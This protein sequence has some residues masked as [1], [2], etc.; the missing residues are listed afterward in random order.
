MYR[1]NCLETVELAT[2]AAQCREELRQYQGQQPVEG[3][4]CLELLR[5]ATLHHVDEAWK[6]L[7]ELFTKPI[8]AW[9]RAHSHFYLAITYDSEENYIAQTF[10]RFW[11]VMRE[12]HLQFT[13]LSA[14]LSYLRLILHSTII[15]TLRSYLR[16]P[17]VSLLDPTVSESKHATFIESDTPDNSWSSIQLLLANEK[18]RQLMYLLYYCGLK[19]REVAVRFPSLFHDVKEIYRLN[20]TIVERLRRNRERLRWMLGYEENTTALCPAA[21]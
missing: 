14:L 21:G 19:P 16:T 3:Y 11:L 13:R 5:R 12:R 20:H 8:G 15:D 1:E 2:L 10:T 18:E 9:L 4:F 17:C 6:I 7:L